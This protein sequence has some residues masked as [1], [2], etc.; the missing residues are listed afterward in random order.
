MLIHTAH[1]SDETCRVHSTPAF[2]SAIQTHFAP[3]YIPTLDSLDM[4]IAKEASKGF[5]DHDSSDPVDEG[6][7]SPAARDDIGNM[8]DGIRKLSVKEDKNTSAA[9]WQ[10]TLSWRALGATLGVNEE[11]MRGDKPGNRATG[12]GAVVKTSE[13]GVE[14][15]KANVCWWAKC[16]TKIR[17]DATPYKRC[18]GCRCVTYVPFLSNFFHPDL[19]LHR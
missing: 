13:S 6:D 17:D 16:D 4:F 2:S 10:V 3:L 12:T 11:I 19:T 9:L 18:S 7:N 1:C 8:E 14:G 15:K 5:I